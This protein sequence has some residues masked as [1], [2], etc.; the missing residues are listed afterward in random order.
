[1]KN[2]ARYNHMMV[3]RWMH[4]LQELDLEVC[5]RSGES[6]LMHL[7]DCLSRAVSEWDPDKG[8]EENGYSAATSVRARRRCATECHL[9]EIGERAGGKLSAGQT[10]NSRSGN[11]RRQVARG[12]ARERHGAAGGAVDD[13][14]RGRSRREFCEFLRAV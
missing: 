5:W 9:R 13:Q 3:Q 11:L 14:R 10:L 7:P 4:D 12:R 8:A 1:M 6:A 2:S